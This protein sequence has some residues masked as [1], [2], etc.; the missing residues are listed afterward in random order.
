MQ[1]IYVYIYI[2]IY[3]YD[4][5]GDV[6]STSETHFAYTNCDSNWEPPQSYQAKSYKGL[7]IS[8]PEQSLK[9]HH[10][11]LQRLLAPDELLYE[12]P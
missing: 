11:W 2:C 7:S 6:A 3:I 4:K 12:C 1:Y 9:G 8:I 10:P 5:T